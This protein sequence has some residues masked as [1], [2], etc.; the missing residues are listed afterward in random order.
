M[1]LTAPQLTKEVEVVHN[2]G[3]GVLNY[4]CSK[5]VVVRV[6]PLSHSAMALLTHSISGQQGKLC[7]IRMPG[8]VPKITV[9]AVPVR[10]SPSCSDMA[11][12]I[13]NTR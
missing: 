1:A 8:H 13:D 2:E 10:G 12:I 5:V 7:T 9:E 11:L 6:I 3:V 4:F